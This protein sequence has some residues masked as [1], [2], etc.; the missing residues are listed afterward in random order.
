M[1]KAW[2]KES[3][4]YQIYPRSFYDSN[5]DGIGDL[6]GIIRKLDYL[7]ELGVNVV[8]LC[9]VYRS[10][11][12]DN[13]YDISDYRDI[14]DE[15]GAL[16]D[17]EELLAGLHARG[18]KL[19]MDLV[20][21]HT[22]DE[23]PWFLKSR[24]SKDT[25]YRDYYIWRPPK[26]GREPNNWRSHFGGSA[27]QYD[28]T[29]GEYYLHLFSRKQPDL[30]WENPKVRAE[31]YEM[32]EW[33]LQK[34]I[35]G[36]RMDVIN[37]ISKTPGLPDAPPVTPDRYQYGGRYF[38]NGPRLMEF[39][40]EMK[41]NVLSNYDI[42]TVGETPGV[43]TRDAIEITDEE[44]GA[45]N[46]VFQFEHMHLDA[47]PGVESSRRSVKP[48]RLLDLKRVM[49]RWQKDLEGKGWNSIYLT[50][51][52]HP[53]AISRFGDDVRY[54]VESAKMLATLTLMLQGTPYVYQGEEI[55]MT[56]VAFESIAD[57][58]DIEALNIY[59][60]LVEEKGFD[61]QIV[62]AT[63]HAKSR[64][65][66][67]T[68]MQWDDGLHAGFTSGSPWIKVNPNYRVINVKQSEADPDS[69][70]WYYHRLIRLRRENPVLVYGVY[71]LIL[72]D[73]EAIYAFTRTFRDDRLLVIL[74]FTG[75]APVFELPVHIPLS[76]KG[77]LIS[78]Y[79]VDPAEDIRRLTLRPFE[80]RV[81]RLRY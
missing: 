75:D 74:N 48:W 51:H 50:N 34:G 76:G 6:R 11:N 4:V 41:R 39:L 44:T 27:W 78:N 24:T 66:A 8:W 3:V 14:M 62:L 46:M 65:N 9:P 15:F 72:E 18:I 32:I 10:P 61:P 69:I 71:D 26:D 59:H 67:R 33:W 25:P 17:W 5:G 20:V 49:T 79:G 64:D 45:L 7:E 60:E 12:D 35:D 53:R 80:A 70:F 38:I 81:Y 30:N 13:G 29:T 58:R 1:R 54:R 43:T 28:E 55:G 68:P 47:E 31:V 21:N 37:M 42:L 23:H 63:L 56:N 22:S 19:V 73:H 77:L 16:A 52:D 57:Y 36:F 40:H 2:W